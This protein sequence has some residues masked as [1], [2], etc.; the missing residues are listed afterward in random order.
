MANILA[1]GPHPD[2]QELGMGATIAKLADQGHDVML[3]DVTNGEPT[4]FG[5]P[6]KRAVETRRATEILSPKDG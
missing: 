3:V 1:I 5:T 4:P 6:E 2:D